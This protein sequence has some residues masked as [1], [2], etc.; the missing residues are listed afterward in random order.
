MKKTLRLGLLAFLVLGALGGLPGNAI[1][2]WCAA[3]VNPPPDPPDD[4]DPRCSPDCKCTNSPCYLGIGAYTQNI[5]DLQIKTAAGFPLIAS[6]RYVSSHVVDGPMGIGWMPSVVSRLSY[7]QFS[8]GGL[9]GGASKRAYVILP[10]GTRV[11]YTENSDG[12]YTPQPGRYDTLIKNADGSFDLILQ[13]TR[14]KIHF[15]GTGYATAIW[16]DYG[17]RLSITNGPTG[18]KPQQIQ[19]LAGSGRYLTI[20][21][22]A[23]GRIA[24]IGDSSGRLYQ[25]AYN[26]DGSLH[27]VTNPLNQVTTYTY[28][29]GRFGPLLSHITDHWNR[30]VAAATYEPGTDRVLTYKED[31]E[32]YNLYP[33]YYGPNTVGKNPASLPGVYR[34]YYFDPTSGLITDNWNGVG[35][36][37]HTDYDANGNVQLTYGRTPKTY[38]TYDTAGNVLSVTVNYQ[39]SAGSPMEK[40]VYTY[41]TTFPSKI[42]SITPQKP[43]P[44]TSPT[45]WQNDLDVWS[46]QYTYYGLS[47]PAPGALK[48]VKRQNVTQMTYVYDL[49][50]RLTQFYPALGVNYATSYAYDAAGNLTTVTLPNNNNTGRQMSYGYDSLG[51]VTSATDPLGKAVTY[52]Y[53]ALDRRTSMTLPPVSTTPG[54]FTTTYAYDTYDASRQLLNTTRTDP[55]GVTTTLGYDAYGEVVRVV[56]GLQRVTQYSYLRGLVSSITDANGYTTSYTYDAGDFLSRTTFA[57]GSAETYGFN[58]MGQLTSRTRG[59]QTV[60]YQYDALLRLQYRSSPYPNNLEIYTHTGQKL[61]QVDRYFNAGLVETDT[62]GYDSALRLNKVT[63]PRGV[64]DYVW[65]TNDRKAS[66]TVEGTPNVTGTYAYY[67]DNSL[68]QITWS[69][70]ASPNVFTFNYDSAGRRTNLTF[71]TGQS[72]NY[73][74]DEQGRL[75]SLVNRTTQGLPLGNLATYSYAYD[76]NQATGVYDRKG[77]RVGMTATVPSLSSYDG[78]TKYEYDLDYEL[79]KRTFPQGTSTSW[80]YDAIGNRTGPGT[81]TYQKIAPNTNNWQRLLSSPVYSFTYDGRGNLATESGGLVETASYDWLNELTSLTGSVNAT[82]TFDYLSRRVTKTIGSGATSTYVYDG[83]K[84]AQEKNGAAVLADYVYGPGMDEP[85]A[86]KW[87]GTV[88]YYMVDGLG[89]VTLVTDTTNSASTTVK[90]KYKWDAWGERLGTASDPVVNPFGYVGREFGDAK[91][92]YFRARYYRPDLGRFEAQDTL[93]IRPLQEASPYPY[94]RNNP[95]LY[96][97]PLG[98]SPWWTEPIPPGWGA[99]F[100][101]EGFDWF[102]LEYDAEMVVNGDTEGSPYLPFTPAWNRDHPIDEWFPVL[103]PPDQGQWLEPPPSPPSF[104]PP[105]PDSPPVPDTPPG[106]PWWLEPPPPPPGPPGPQPPCPTGPVQ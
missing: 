54:T 42:A 7:T 102:I 5:L 13:H 17:N 55:N 1:A 56:D 94:S 37:Q 105:V 6:R 62:L 76:L 75:L 38:F 80:T 30:E 74:Y 22:G 98:R 9:G 99:F 89:S 92:L 70:M 68:K 60:N 104:P 47:D 12:T 19:D 73:T 34:S 97:D 96:R 10:D 14:S 45:Q 24:T 88:Y 67:N 43:I 86:M 4:P 58:G 52:I 36:N 27:T 65:N 106:P 57:D 72:R 63:T 40:Y 23:D 28:D 25:Y 11:K 84:I 44:N 100:L 26:L 41:D 78:L 31:G 32:T 21:W 82:Y 8:T 20:T 79:T 15:G 90:D 48:Q 83:L 35:V 18:M 61:T 85:L 50:G 3:P 71:P 101:L 49:Q 2:N 46:W 77:Q 16:D 29:N 39:G 69:A 51:R 93:R 87:N 33:G 95:L 59:G 91:D 53:D 66:Y 103:V 64:V 81:W